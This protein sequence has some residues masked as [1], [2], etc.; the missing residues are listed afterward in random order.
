MAASMDKLFVREYECKN[1]DILTINQCEIGDVGCVVW[2]A[3]LVLASYLETEDWKTNSGENRLL[4]KNVL[5]LGAGT[6]LVGL[7]AAHL[8]YFMMLIYNRRF[9][10]FCPVLSKNGYYKNIEFFGGSPKSRFSYLSACLILFLW[11]FK[12]VK[13]LNLLNIRGGKLARQ[14]WDAIHLTVSHF[15]DV[16]CIVGRSVIF[17]IGAPPPPLP[18]GVH[19]ISQSGIFL[20]L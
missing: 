20:G 4:N 13:L 6:G 5:E 3:A 12:T 19:S 1:G 10:N 2:D 9:V 18:F 7:Q 16:T 17:Y 11:N 8:G 14:F 15:C